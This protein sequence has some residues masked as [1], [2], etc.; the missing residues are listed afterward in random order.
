MIL[1]IGQFSFYFRKR[2]NH[3]LDNEKEK[4]KSPNKSPTFG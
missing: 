4:E 2:K 3:T 1:N